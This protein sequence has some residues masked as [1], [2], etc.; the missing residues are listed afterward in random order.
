MSLLFQPRYEPYDG[1]GV[2]AKLPP[3]I[4]VRRTKAG[5]PFTLRDYQV[6]DC[7]EVMQAWQ[8][9]KR[10]VVV[11]HSTGMGKSVLI[12]ELAKRRT[13]GRVL[14]LVDSEN[15]VK[16]LY[17]TCM[18]HH[19]EI[20]GILTGKM[21]SHWQT[22]RVVV[23]TVQ[24]LYYGKPGEERFRQM[25]P[26]DYMTVLC[27]ECESSIA[28]RFGQTVLWFMDGNPECKL[29]GCSATPFRGDG[30]PMGELY[31]YAHNEAGPLNRN[32]MWG[33]MNGWLVKPRQAFVTCNLDFSSIKLRKQKD[34]ER[35]YSDKDIAALLENAD[36]REMLKM[37][38]AMHRVAHGKPSIVIC[39]NSVAIAKTVAGY[40]CSAAGDNHAAHA[41]YGDQ[42][43]YADTLMDAYKNGEFQHAVSV[44]KLYKGFDADRVRYVFMLRKT[45]SK[46]L[47][48]QSMGRG[49]R[50]LASIR[51]LL[52]AEPTPE[53]RMEIIRHSAKPW[54]CMVDLVGIQP[55]AKDTGV[56]DI[57]G[58]HLPDALRRRVIEDSH[59]RHANLPEPG[60][61][62]DDDDEA[63]L[64][65]VG[66]V[67]REVNKQMQIEAK[68]RQEEEERRRR[69]IIQVGRADVQVRYTDNLTQAGSMA[70]RPQ[71]WSRG[72]STGKQVKLLVAFGVKLETAMAAS[73]LKAG[74]MIQT[75]KNKGTKPNWSHL[76]KH[77]V[78]N[79]DEI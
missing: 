47:Y 48:A 10:S 59:Q 51:E 6:A 24:S 57:I 21:K 36:E 50:P 38:E 58:E 56:I 4:E 79:W 2:I 75:Y 64:F 74:A 16:D 32:I 54:M 5:K 39:P 17:R 73:K 13:Q 67:A 55:D 53:G 77:Q 31:E 15:L 18:Q 71:R 30:K 69:S 25:N 41:I 37:A 29:M 26:A 7:D 49:T 72:S 60:T 61:F 62:E 70:H 63:G 3:T 20:P 23:A 45:K 12:A 22:A 33:V 42:G 27:D 66:Q 8:S 76:R 52:Q 43:D 1:D 34:G 65:D 9:G 35:D 78:G 68:K 11:C 19:G 44:N 14:I 40:L 28:T 46:R